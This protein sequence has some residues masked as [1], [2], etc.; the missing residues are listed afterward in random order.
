MLHD[1]LAIAYAYPPFT[2]TGTHRMV[3][4]ARY[5]PDFGY[6]ATMLT[7]NS[8]GTLPDDEENRVVRADDII[9]TA[10]RLYQKLAGAHPQHAQDAHPTTAADGG[11]APPPD[12]LIQRMRTLLSIPEQ[13]IV[14]YPQAVR[15]ARHLAQQ[16]PFRIIF[17][18]SP[19]ETDHLVALAL[20]RATG[21]PWVIDFRDG[22]MFEPLVPYRQT[23]PP[24]RAIESRMERAVLRHADAIV[25]TSEVMAD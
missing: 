21:L 4:F 13:R 23:L 1:V 6:R 18:T 10:R 19:P 5:L 12:S 7:T 9:G 3:N 15:A 11:T 14:W 16:H 24:R 22:W 8:R 25:T 20:K 17:S 2:G